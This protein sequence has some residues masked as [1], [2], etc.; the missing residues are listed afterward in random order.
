[1]DGATMQNGSSLLSVLV[2][3]DFVAENPPTWLGSMQRIFTLYA[4][5]YPFMAK[6]F[7]MSNYDT[8]SDNAGEIAATLS[9]PITDAHYMPVTRDLSDAK[10]KSMIHWLTSPGPDGKPLRGTPPAF[11]LAKESVEA[12]EQGDSKTR[13]FK[14]MMN[15]RK[16][17]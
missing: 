1:M 8:L 16:Q 6:F 15:A 9:L 14:K 7:D 13:A 5:L 2:W 17:V 4:N 12:S 10:K 3:D 11:A